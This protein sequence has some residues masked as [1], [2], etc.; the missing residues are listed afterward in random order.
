MDRV[1]GGHPLLDDQFRAQISAGLKALRPDPPLSERL[2]FIEDCP[3]L[4]T[5]DLERGGTITM[6][7]GST[8]EERTLDENGVLKVRI[9]AAET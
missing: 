3:R 6:C 7:F 4:T 5:F 8:F 2:G 9:L 1:A